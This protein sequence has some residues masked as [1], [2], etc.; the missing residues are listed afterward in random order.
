MP[1]EESSVMNERMRFVV[2]LEQGE[3]MTDLCQEFGISRKTGYKIWNRYQEFGE[4]GLYNLS[5]TP[6]RLFRHTSDE[7]RQLILKTKAEF[8]T[9]G[10]KKLL[11]KLQQRHPGIH[12]PVKSTIHEILRSQGLVKRRRNRR[13]VPTYAQPLKEGQAPND[14][15]CADFKGQFRLGN[16]SYCYPLTISDHYSRYLIGC[17]A[18]ES[19]RGD[20]ARLVFEQAFGTYGLPKR[21]RTDNGA[22]F[23]TRGIAGLSLLSTWWIK[24]GICP[25]RII[26]G[27]PEQ[28]G[29][30]ERMHL[31]L[32]EETTRPPGN[33]IIQQQE[34]FDDFREEYNTA[35]PHEA[36]GM[37]CPS[38]VY[39]SSDRKMETEED[40]HDYPLHDLVKRVNGCG[41][42]SL[43]TKEPR[44]FLGRTLIGEYVGLREID[45]SR[46]LVSFYDL[47]LGVIDEQLNEFIPGDL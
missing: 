28:N 19:T 5:R 32:K 15:W 26:P 6:H 3:R 37:G 23:A 30:H 40:I 34:R 47:D 13:F 25:E 39:V 29:R 9:W 1:W 33:N 31:T 8:R 12:F 2:R 18:L 36:L 11:V 22:P 24:L 46:W 43:H 44:F 45:P 4:K 20:T 7:I 14:L 35:R 38:D 16:R 27:H 21:I 17:E 10:A 42:I 41:K